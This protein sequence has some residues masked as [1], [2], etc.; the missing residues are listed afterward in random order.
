VERERDIARNFFAAYGWFQRGGQGMT[1]REVG[2]L[3]C[4]HAPGGLTDFN[5]AMPDPDR[6]A[7]RGL[8]LAAMDRAKDFFRQR[9]SPFACW[10]PGAPGSE[11][12]PGFARHDYTGQHLALERLPPPGDA[13]A[14][15]LVRRVTRAEE[16]DAFADTIAAGWS[17]PAEPYREFFASQAGRLLRADCPKRLYIGWKDEQP[18]CCLELFTQP[19]EGVA[20]LYYV[21]TRREFRRRGYG[22]RIQDQALRQAA[23]GG[24]RAAVVVSRP[25]ERRLLARCGFVDCGAWHEY[26]EK[27]ATR[28]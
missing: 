15:L 22:L 7:P 23:A 9:G 1:V 24:C 11:D 4:F 20:G 28:P 2:G 8:P 21:V 10:L 27:A 13:G 6:A 25:A 12:A 5:F 3:T 19:E 14:D 18:I 26:V 17:T 16:L